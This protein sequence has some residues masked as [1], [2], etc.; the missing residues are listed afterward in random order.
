MAHTGNL[1][2]GVQN[3]SRSGRLVGKLP[4]KWDNQGSQFETIKLPGKGDEKGSRFE[5]IKFPVQEQVAPSTMGNTSVHIVHQALKNLLKVKGIVLRKKTVENFLKAVDQVAPWFLV[6]GHLTMSSWK[7]NSK[8]I[9]GL[10]KS[11]GY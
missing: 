2:F 5:T 1:P 4:G 8:G 7:K 6:S 9:C 11:K 3:S 10:L